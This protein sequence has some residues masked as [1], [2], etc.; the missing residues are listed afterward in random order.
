MRAAH[1][2]AFFFVMDNDYLLTNF[3]FWITFSVDKK[4]KVLKMSNITKIF[5]KLCKIFLK[6]TCQKICTIQKNILL[7][8]P[9]SCFAGLRRKVA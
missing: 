5:G 8:Q 9:F 1:G 2:A 6:K 3:A 4:C 7:L